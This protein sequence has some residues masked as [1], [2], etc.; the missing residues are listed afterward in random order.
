MATFYEGTKNDQMVNESIDPVILRLLGIVDVSDIDYDTYKTLLREVLVAVRRGRKISAEEDELLR[1][2]FKR[3]RNSTGRFKVK[4]K[5]M[6]TPALPG[7]TPRRQQ[8]RTS[9]P[10]QRLLPSSVK[11]Q[12]LEDK[13]K[14]LGEGSKMGAMEFLR[15][16]VAPALTRIETSLA[17]ILEARIA[18]DEADKKTNEENRRQNEED[19]KRAKENR[20]EGAGRLMRGFGSQA[21]A[22]TPVS[23]MMDSVMNFIKNIVGGILALQLLEFL[24]DPGKY[25]RNIANALIGFAND[26]IKNIFNFV[27]TPINS[28]ID[29]L[30]DALQGFA[31]NF[32]E[33]V[34]QLPLVPELEI[35]IIEKPEVP[36]IPLIPEPPEQNSQ[37]LQVPT[38]EGGGINLNLSGIGGGQVTGRS[39]QRISGAGPDT[40]LV[41]LQPGEV[42]MSNKAVDAYG[43]NNLLE[44]NALAGGT[45]KPGS[46]RIN[47]AR[48][49]TMQGGGV[50]GGGLNITNAK[51]TYYDP[52]LGGINA[53]GYKT[54]SGLPATSTG[55]GYRP[56]VFSAAAFPPLIQAL[57]QSMTVPTSSNFPG[58]RTIKRPFNVRVTNKI[59]KQAIIR[60]NDVG[61]GVAGH[62]PNHML[63]L[64]VAAKD[65]LGTGEGFTIQM[66]DLDA[67]AGPVNKPVIPSASPSPSSS[68]TSVVSAA[69][70]S[71]TTVKQPPAPP[72]SGS[73][74]IAPVP[75]GEESPS[76]AA[77]A[78][79]TVA[80]MFNPVDMNNPELL[81][82]KS[83]FNIVG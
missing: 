7:S 14:K 30:N 76:S 63:D 81:I 83:I 29:T 1:E 11:P 61:P 13:T 15:R 18:Q 82:V 55:E 19:K 51:T 16:V 27:M 36:Q 64:S 46:A 31:K 78:N 10:Q 44:M 58:G 33:S 34:G 6:S 47:G 17:N 5:R 70:V 21:M 26:L 39:G 56:E 80:E 28:F 25:L 3:V 79:N 38:M 49:S 59:G 4:Q 74:T 22:L 23:N 71:A 35:P 68:Q 60:V 54:A 45:N 72:G 8:Q 48:F 75:V 41:A 37:P 73:V 40:Q 43:L 32:N 42:V 67:V 9:T 12:D 66:A 2:E 57:P 69:N 65:Y 52:A 53:S 24:K 77:L 50:V 20:L 62:S